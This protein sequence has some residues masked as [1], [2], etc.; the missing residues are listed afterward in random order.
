MRVK[1]PVR[2]ILRIVFRGAPIE[3]QLIVTRR[4]NLSCGYCTEYDKVSE[5]IPL[6]VLK[7]RIDALHGLHV[8]N[9]ALLGGEPLLH[10]QLPEVVAYGDRRAQVSVTTNG[11]LLTEELI[12]R[13]NAAGLAN[14]EVSID[15]VSADRTAYIQKCLKT[16]RPKL[17]LLQRFAKF[18]VFINMV[19]C[20]QTRGE[21]EEAIRELHELGFVVTI[22]LLHDARGAIQ[23]AGKS[24]QD[25]WTQFYVDRT[26]Q[27]YLDQDYGAQLLAGRRPKWQCGAGSRFLYVDEFGMVQFCSAQRGRL[28]KPIAEYTRRDLQAHARTYKGCEEGCALLCVYR[29]SVLDNRPLHTLGSMLRMAWRTLGHRGNVQHRRVD[30]SRS[31]S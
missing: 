25:L 5:F 8:V 14:M 29:D 1:H 27:A 10:P 19:L 3:G 13:F 4:C 28:N 30:R 31:A 16:I 12:Q 23:I 15:A 9:I 11:F 18:D 6:E 24:Y 26:P 17:G 21:F 2:T 22:D 7:R 20:E